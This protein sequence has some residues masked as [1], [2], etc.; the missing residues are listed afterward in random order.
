MWTSWQPRF[1]YDYFWHEARQNHLWKRLR[2]DQ[3]PVAFHAALY[4]LA[5]GVSMAPLADPL[6]G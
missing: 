3:R 4:I 2:R 5:D 6:R 1:L